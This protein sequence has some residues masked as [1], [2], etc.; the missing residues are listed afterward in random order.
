MCI[1]KLLPLSC[2]EM[3][4]RGIIMRDCFLLYLSSNNV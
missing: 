3:C 4:C 2:L 1:V